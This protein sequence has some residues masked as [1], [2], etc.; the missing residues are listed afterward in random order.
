MVPLPIR[1]ASQCQTTLVGNFPPSP[2]RPLHFF[3]TPAALSFVF[4]TEILKTPTNGRRR[5]LRMPSGARRPSPPPGT[6]S[7]S[8]ACA[9]S[10][11]SQT[12]HRR[13][14]PHHDHRRIGVAVVLR[15]SFSTPSWGS[16]FPGAQ[17]FCRHPRMGVAVHC[18]CRAGLGA[19]PPPLGTLSPSSACEVSAPSQT[20]HRR[21][22]IADTH[23]I[24]ITD[25]WGWPS[26]SVVFRT[27]FS[28]PSWGSAFPGGGATGARSCHPRKNRTYS[29]TYNKNEDLIVL[30]CRTT[31]PFMADFRRFRRENDH[32]NNS[33][34]YAV[35]RSFLL[36]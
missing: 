5:P 9:V 24:T 26:F 4:C 29:H 6:L 13:H 33:V 2:A 1:A 3:D 8:S 12:H 25:E 28:T 14:P 34:T 36:F 19:P 30:F 18:V 27:S 7:P 32:C 11:P 17:K 15:T 10:A 22:T 35:N 21:R 23:P 16:A 20:R 31:P